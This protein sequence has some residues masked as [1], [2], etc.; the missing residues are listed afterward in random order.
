MAAASLD[1]IVAITGFTI[2][3]GLAMDAGSNNNLALSA[4][5][6]G[7][8]TLFLGVVSGCIG[9]AILALTRY[10]SDSWQRSVIAIELALLMTYGYKMI[11][12]DGCGAVA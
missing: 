12:F 4:F 6:H 7:P 10:C 1:D 8:V 5:I 9:G 2:C 3:I 11:H